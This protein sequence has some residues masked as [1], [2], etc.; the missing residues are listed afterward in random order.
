MRKLKVV[1]LMDEALVPPD[2]VKG[3]SPEEIEP[4]RTEYDVVTALKGMGHDVLKI[5]LRDELTPLRLAVKNWQPDIAFNLLEEFQGETTY[6]YLVVSYLESMGVPYTGCNP[7]GLIL[8]RDKGIS[9][10]LLAYHRIRTP[11]FAVFPRKKRVR[12]PRKLAYPLIVKSLVEEASLGISQASIVESDEKLVERVEFI[13]ESIKTDAIV[14][15]YIAGRELYVGV[16]GNQRLEVLPTWEMLFANM[17]A[18]SAPIAT[19]RV[20]WSRKY[21][22][23]HSIDTA[24]AKDLPEGAATRISALSRRIYR[25][26]GLSGYARL[27]YRMSEEGEIY[28][29]EANPNP[30]LARGEDLADSAE[31]AGVSYEELLQKILT[32]GFRA[33]K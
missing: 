6:D 33:R 14:E 2:D 24:A 26:L 3:L 25:I 8:S 30:Q 4:W 32:T 16:I 13:H 5:G 27:D 9:K 28:L 17:P 12:R 29:L 31:A 10:K 21:Q 19:R 22:K 15:H 23:K 1:A 18:D 20:K 11:D 7:R